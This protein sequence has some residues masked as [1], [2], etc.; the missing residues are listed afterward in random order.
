[1]LYQVKFT[2]SAAKIIKNLSPET[3]KAA[4]SALKELSQNPDLGKEL[5]A[6]LSSFRTYRFKRYRIVYD[7]DTKDKFIIVWAI[8][9]RR[10][11][12]E[13]LGEQ[14]LQN[15]GDRELDETF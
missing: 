5:Q 15:R 13:H 4:K 3:K 10:D 12:Y 6:E 14:L 11:I 8:G 2:S 1:M 9:H 7:I